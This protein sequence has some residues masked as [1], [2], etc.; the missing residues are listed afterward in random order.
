MIRAAVLGEDVSRSRSP[1][2]HNAAYA[3]LGIQGDYKAVSVAG[4]D[5]RKS[6][7]ALISE[8]YSYVNV[9]IPHKKLAAKL[10]TRRSLAVELTGAANTLVFKRKAG[11]VEILADN[12]DGQGLL[13][14]LGDLGVTVTRSTRVALVGAG[15]AAAGALLAFVKKGAR[16]V[17]VS[18]RLAPARALKKRLPAALQTRV[19]VVALDPDTLM[20]RLPEVD[21]LVSAV[22]A[23]AW[24]ERDLAKALKAL[25]KAAAVVEMAYGKVSPL[26][27][28]V[29]R[30]TPRYQDGLPMLVHQAAFALR[31][32]LRK[33][34]P[35][36][37][38][39]VAA[40]AKPAQR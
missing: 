5:F 11:V 4:R 30:H 34:P 15:G 12:T 13:A 29:R 26:A 14:A 24:E 23:H 8:G 36:D 22:P 31:L 27:V 17:L 28:A 7:R 10:A 25:P 16:V 38:M 3:A 39:F 37:A 6:V 18:R 32:A 19:E 35:L 40:R 33:P 1:Q 2:I 20:E 9:T 21:V